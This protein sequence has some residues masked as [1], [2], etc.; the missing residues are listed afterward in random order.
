MHLQ[1]KTVIK[2]SLIYIFIVTKATSFH[3][4]LLTYTQSKEDK[5]N[6]NKKTNF[7]NFSP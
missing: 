5:L 3:D 4:L 2:K 6:T 7:T 1:Y